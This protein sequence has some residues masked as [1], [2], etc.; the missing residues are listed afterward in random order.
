MNHSPHKGLDPE[1]P[2]M[3]EVRGKKVIERGG[4]GGDGEKKLSFRPLAVLL[5]TKLGMESSSHD[6]KHLTS[7]YLS[8]ILSTFIMYGSTPLKYPTVCMAAIVCFGWEWSHNKSDAS[9]LLTNLVLPNKPW[10]LMP[11]RKLS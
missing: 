7:T 10:G 6:F 8:Y 2:V 4:G 11:C 5:S 3:S 9:S 1:L